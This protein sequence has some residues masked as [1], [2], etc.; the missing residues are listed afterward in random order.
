MSSK[1]MTGQPVASEA[2]AVSTDLHHEEEVLDE[3]Y[4]ITVPFARPTCQCPEEIRVM[5]PAGCKDCDLDLKL[6]AFK[7]AYGRTKVRWAWFSGARALDDDLSRRLGTLG[8]LPFEVRDKIFRLVLDEY[9]EEALAYRMLNDHLIRYGLLRGPVRRRG[10]AVSWLAMKQQLKDNVEIRIRE[11]Y[12]AHESKDPKLCKVFCPRQSPFAI[13]PDVV[14]PLRLATDDTKFEI[15]RVFL[16]TMT[17]DFSCPKALQLFL[18]ELS[19]VQLSQVRFITIRIYGCNVCS[20]SDNCESCYSDIYNEETYY[21]WGFLCAKLP[22]T[23]ISINFDLSSKSGG[24]YPTCFASSLGPEQLRLAKQGMQFL[25]RQVRRITLE[26]EVKLLEKPDPYSRSTPRY[27]GTSPSTVL[28]G[29]D[30]MVRETDVLIGDAEKKLRE[31]IRR[32]RNF[33]NPEERYQIGPM[34]PM[35]FP[36]P[37]QWAGTL[38][39]IPYSSFAGFAN[40]EEHYQM[41]PMVPPT[42]PRGEGHGQ[43]A[44]TLHG[45]PYS[46]FAGF[47]N[48]EEHY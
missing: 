48:P 35:T 17:F 36:R 25:R 12:L 4:A 34:V 26:T 46:S 14:M 39:G 32:G 2:D 38:H 7:Q 15:D 28:N 20:C 37:G 45:V 44:G 16:S 9:M 47:A 40:P 41:G 10:D 6:Q 23:L 8:Y 29:L 19:V 42:F 31:D 3:Y 24:G 27:F 30:V 33:T 11:A 5:E 1:I 18:K 43:W 21:K 22:S 13:L